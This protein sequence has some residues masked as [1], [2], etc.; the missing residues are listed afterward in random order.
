MLQVKSKF[1]D[2]TEAT[3]LAEPDTPYDHLVQ[4]MDAVRASV[5]PKGPSWCGPSSSR[6]SPS[7]TRRCAARQAA[8][9]RAAAA[10]PREPADGRAHAAPTRSEHR[11]RNGNMVDMNL[12][13]LIDV[14]TILIF[15]LLSSAAGVETLVSPKA[16]NL[17]VS[18]AEKAP[19]QTVVLV[20]SADDDPGRGPAH[21]QRGQVMA[22]R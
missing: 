2:K 22:T 17:P 5:R 9:R 14:F 20:V 12:V 6:T 7:A 3:V 10:P 18:N 19:E 16:V 4:V 8:Q 21:R 13:A 11:A 1:P 15:F